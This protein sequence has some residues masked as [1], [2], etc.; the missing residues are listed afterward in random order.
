MRVVHKEKAMRVKWRIS[1]IVL[2]GSWLAASAAYAWDGVVS[3]TVVAFEVTGGNNFGF[4]VFISG[5]TNM[6]GTGSNW[7]FLNETDSNYK[8]YVSAILTAKAQGNS[9]TMYTTVDNGYCRIG[10][11]SVH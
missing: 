4:R 8:T 7:G 5:V 2:A 10:Y 11:L 9:V 1:C 3:G 6:C